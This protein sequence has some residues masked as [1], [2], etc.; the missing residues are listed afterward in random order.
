MGYASMLIHT[1][2][3]YLHNH[4]QTYSQRAQTHTQNTKS[5]LILTEKDNVKW[6]SLLEESDGADTMPEAVDL[7]K[8]IAQAL[9][10]QAMEN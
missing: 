10:H 9:H 2:Q 6:K 5:P 7:R 3:M 4:T 1:T 8:H